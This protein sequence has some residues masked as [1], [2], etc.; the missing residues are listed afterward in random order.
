MHSQARLSC[1]SEI[2]VFRERYSEE[3]NC[4]IVHD[5][6]RRRTGWTLIYVLELDAISVGFGSVAIGGPWKNRPTLFEFYVLP[7]YRSFSFDLYETLLSVSGPK[8]MEIQSNDLLPTVMLHTYTHE[9]A[10]ERIVFHDK[11]TTALAA[12]GATLRRISSDEETGAYI[13]RREG[14]PEWVLELDGK[15]VAQGGI[16]F[17]YNRPYGDIHME[18]AEVFRRRGLGSYLVQELKRAAY[19]LG[20]VPCARCNTTN[21]RR[22]GLRKRLDLFPSRTCSPVLSRPEDKA[23]PRAH[24]PRVRKVRTKIARMVFFTLHSML[25]TQWPNI[26]SARITGNPNGVKS[27]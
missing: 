16:L 23:W 20:S 3:M 24:R 17:H 22:V 26:G 4:Q 7:Q 18:V 21:V 14:G 25:A 9:I 27:W 13:E 19:E 15:V 5:S 8:F 2:L 1:A 11:V 12:N 6:I 10:S